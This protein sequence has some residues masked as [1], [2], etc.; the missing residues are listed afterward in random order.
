VGSR[1]EMLRGE[2]LGPA[3]ARLVFHSG[4]LALDDPRIVPLGE[5]YDE[6]LAR[7]RRCAEGGLRDAVAGHEA[8]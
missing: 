4:L 1:E 6:L 7:L 3:P 5:T 8:K 2:R